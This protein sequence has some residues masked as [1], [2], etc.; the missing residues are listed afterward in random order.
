[1]DLFGMQ[2]LQKRIY[3]MMYIRYC[4]TIYTVSIVFLEKCSKR[5]YCREPSTIQLPTYSARKATPAILLLA[6]RE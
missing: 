6:I 4:L 5:S 1:M 3:I 2:V